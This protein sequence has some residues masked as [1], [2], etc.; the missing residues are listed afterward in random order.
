MQARILDHLGH[1]LAEPA[2]SGQSEKPFM[3]RADVTND[4]FAVNNG[5]RLIGIREQVTQDVAREFNR[6][7]KFEQGIIGFAHHDDD[8]CCL[9]GRIG[10]GNQRCDLVAKAEDALASLL[11]MT[12]TVRDPRGETRIA[13]KSTGETGFPVQAEDQ[14]AAVLRIKFGEW[15]GH[16]YKAIASERGALTRS[17]ASCSDLECCRHSVFREDTFGLAIGVAAGSVD[18]TAIAVLDPI[19]SLIPFR[20]S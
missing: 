10:D 16:G 15:R 20:L 19:D 3:D 1:M 18:G 12:P 11:S 4:S 6:G 13:C 7:C 17:G 2:A 14:N 8:G 9:G 5:Q